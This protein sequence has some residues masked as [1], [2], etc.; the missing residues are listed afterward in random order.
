[1]PEV[2][3]ISRR[4]T[5]NDLL[6]SIRNA[7]KA[8][9]LL[10]RMIV[11][12]LIMVCLRL[13]IGMDM[14]IDLPGPNAHLSD[15]LPMWREI[16]NFDPKNND[17]AVL[18]I[19]FCI[20]RNIISQCK[21]I[22]KAA[23]QEQLRNNP[24]QPAYDVLISHQQFAMLFTEHF[25]PMYNTNH[26]VS[27]EIVLQSPMNYFPLSSTI[28]QNARLVLCVSHYLEDITWL[29]HVDTPFIVASKTLSTTDPA[30]HIDV[31]AG[32]E[33][34]SYLGQRLPTI[35]YVNTLTKRNPMCD[36]LTGY[37]IRYYDDLPTY[38]L[39][40]HG[41][42]SHWHQIYN[43]HYIIYHLDFNQSYRNINNYWVN[44][45]NT[46]SNKYM[47]RLQLL[48]KDLFEDELGIM[49]SQVILTL[50]MK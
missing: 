39:F 19:K 45:R 31:N 15:E 38:T 50:A 7:V 40:L 20:Q 30:I 5:N 16:I 29:L 21:S 12:V 9:T 1:M 6:N 46:S 18:I 47:Q 25:V 17:L 10:M 11:V 3:V 35:V 2:V 33:V 8:R 49:P 26:P 14:V 44:D 37:I 34:S 48:W 32:N 43:M 42:D 4:W 28:I 13:S 24:L 22:F 23:V 27:S 41:H 36:V